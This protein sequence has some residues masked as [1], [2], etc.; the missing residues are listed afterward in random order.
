MKNDNSARFVVA[1][2]VNG[3]ILTCCTV[4]VLKRHACRGGGAHKH[5]SFLQP[6]V[7]IV[8][9]HLAPGSDLSPICVEA[10]PFFPRAVSPSFFTFPLSDLSSRSGENDTFWLNRHPRCCCEQQHNGR[11]VERHRR[12]VFDPTRKNCRETAHGGRWRRS[13][14]R[15]AHRCHWWR[16]RIWSI[17]PSRAGRKDGFQRV[18]RGRERK[19]Q[20]GRPVRRSS[21]KPVRA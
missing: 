19:R 11:P 20:R 5:L 14:R 12:S 1:S 9:L 16:N 13:H 15:P 7:M 3:R 2:Q 17:R 8:F 6:F 21:S 4:N 10:L 18:D